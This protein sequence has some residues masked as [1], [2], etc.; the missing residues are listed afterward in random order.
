MDSASSAV[1]W[2]PIVTFLLGYGI[3]AASD[4]VQHRRTVERDRETRKETRRDRLAEDRRR[5]Q[6]ETLLA[7]QEATMEQIRTTAS[8]HHQDEMAFR[9]T[10][11]WQKQLFGEDLSQQDHLAMRKTVMLS[12]RVHDDSLRELLD[13]FRAYSAQTTISIDKDSSDAAMSN[14]ARHF[15]QIQ[16]RIGHLI[17]TIDDDEDSLIAR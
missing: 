2:F 8:M 7:L 10:G 17:R 9:K 15:E 13:R 6:R 12:Q 14:M 11:L 16:G 4:W 5:F 3:K 1:G